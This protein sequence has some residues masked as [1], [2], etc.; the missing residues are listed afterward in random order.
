MPVN[1]IYYH[2]RLQLIIVH[3]RLPACSL[4]Q[5]F[6]PYSYLPDWQGEG[7]PGLDRWD[8]QMNEWTCTT[9]LLHS[10]QKK[11]TDISKAYEHITRFVCCCK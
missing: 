7:M 11:R 4:I 5:G 9:L 3:M 8:P 10:A 1:T 6:S 2:T